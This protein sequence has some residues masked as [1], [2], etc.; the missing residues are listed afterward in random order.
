MRLTIIPSDNKVGIDNNF[1]VD[2][3]LS[4]CSIPE[5]IHAL[6]WYETEG[7]VEFI[8][9]PDRTKPQNEIIQSLPEWALN[10]IQVWEAWT[11]PP[12]P[13]PPETQ[14]PLTII[15]NAP[16]TQE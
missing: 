3:N 2:L 4:V 8:N 1:I 16:V 12:P 5:N 11:P 9:N 7:E 15:R 10:C 13:P 6:Q 14:I